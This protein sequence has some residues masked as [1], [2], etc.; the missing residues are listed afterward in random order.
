M[1]FLVLLIIP[2]LLGGLAF[3]FLKGITW[4]E[5]LLQVAASILVAGISAWAVSCANTQDTE[6]WNGVVQSKKQVW[7]SC[8][9]SYSCNCHEV[10]SGSGKN[11]SCSTHCDTCY[12]HSNDWDWNVY[13]SN[14]ETIGIARIDRRGSFEPPRWTAVKIGEPTA[15][16]HSYTNYVKAAPDTVLRKQGQTEKYKGQIPPYPQ[17]VYDYYRLNRLVLDGVAVPDPQAW[18]D[19]L[20]AINGQIGHEKQANL[21]LVLTTK[22]QDFYYALEQEWIGGKK[23][24]A[25]LVVGVDAELHPKWAQVMAWETNHMYEVRLQDDIMDEGTLTLDG[26]M[27]AMLVNTTKY[28]ERKPMHDYEYLKASIVPTPTQWAL[29][30]FINLAVAL[31]LLWFFNAEDVFG[32]EDRGYSRYNRRNH[33]WS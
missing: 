8:S 18:I 12:E 17:N 16:T 11:R 20:S 10:C 32:D 1:I 30:L 19:R 29:A 21:I 3:A 6:V 27:Q 25:I 24:D 31:G 26:T 4:K 9:H 14:G 28:H 22:P 15:V 2:V 23:N 13:T 33:R 5:A 7:T